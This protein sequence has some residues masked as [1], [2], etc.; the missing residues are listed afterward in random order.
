MCI[1]TRITHWRATGLLPVICAYAAGL[2]V[3]GAHDVGL[4]LAPREGA[5]LLAFSLVG[6][7]VLY[8]AYLSPQARAVRQHIVSARRMDR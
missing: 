3:L 6:G 4:G 7:S 8:A 5:Y 2:A 1:R